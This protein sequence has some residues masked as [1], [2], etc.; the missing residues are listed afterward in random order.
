MKKEKRGKKGSNYKLRESHGLIEDVYIVIGSVDWLLSAWNDKK[1]ER[2]FIV[3]DE[4]CIY[5]YKV[6]NEDGKY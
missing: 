5:I 4:S 6:W 1:N 3:C 2:V